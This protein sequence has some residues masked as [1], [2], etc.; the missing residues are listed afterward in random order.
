MGATEATHAQ[1][2]SGPGLPR[3]QVPCDICQVSDD[4]FEVEARSLYSDER[5]RIVRCRRCGLVYV[6]PRIE[7]QAK[8]A[9]IAALSGTMSVEDTQ[10]RDGGVHKLVLDTLERHCPRGR[11]LDV[12]CA[13]GG[14]LRQARERGWQVAGVE[15]ARPLAEF[16]AS[17]YG[18]DVR[19]ATLESAGFAEATFDAVVMVNTIEH[20]Y[21]PARVVREAFRILRPGG[22]LY[23]M[24]PDYDHR[25][26]RLVQAF[27]L[28]KD[29]DRLDPTAHPYYFTPRTHATLVERQG[30]SVITCG[31]PISGLGA[32]RAGASGWRSR[33]FRTALRPVAWLSRVVPIGSTVQCVARRPA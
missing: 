17:R 11:L 27:G 15:A 22:V 21:H 1:G 2:A 8:L 10:S 31:S 5:F 6:N 30:F 29:A 24:T 12:G 7:E 19:A 20:L 33:L 16:A 25:L 26:V 13:T 4:D 3:E 32:E 18:L 23:S 9:H 28:M 14:L